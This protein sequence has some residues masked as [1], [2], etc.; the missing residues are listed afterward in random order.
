MNLGL[1]GKKVL[2]TGAS[3]GIGKAIAKGF[4][5]EE[6]LVCISSRR[7]KNLLLAEKK[8]SSKFGKDFVYAH[9][10]DFTNL[11]EVIK[12]RSNIKKQFN[13]LD[14]VIANVGDG[15]SEQGTL[16]E[17]KQWEKIWKANF[18]TAI[19]TARTF[20]PMLEETKG[21]LLFISSITGLEAFGAPVDYST[22]KSALIALSKNMARKIA[23]KVRI[24]VIAPGNIYFKNGSWDEKIKNDKKRVE[25]LL[26]KTVPMKR[27]G[28]PK[29]I[30]TAALFLCSEKAE[31]I[32]GAVLVV[33]GGQTVGIF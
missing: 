9:Q 23:P 25:E 12:L 8:L 5:E 24:N 7:S 27:F 31:F 17:K 14:I 28:K 15:R 4:L 33:D 22:A 13:Q 26:K 18:D 16:P 20:L 2:V 32:T 11:N 30:A 29:D 19:H 6:A 21:N 10:C 1:K 3:R